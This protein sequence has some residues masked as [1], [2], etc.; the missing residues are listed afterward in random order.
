MWS[1]VTVENKRWIIIDLTVA[2]PLAATQGQEMIAD[3]LKTLAY[4]LRQTQ[5]RTALQ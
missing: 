4:Q 3:A 1:K 5:S 2:G